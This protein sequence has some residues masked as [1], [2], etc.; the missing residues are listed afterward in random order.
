[1]TGATRDSLGRLARPLSVGSR[2][3]WGALTAGAIL[4]LLGGAAWVVQLGWITAPYWVLATWLL[5]AL[6]AALLCRAALRSDARYSAGGIAAWLEEHGIWRRGAI[7]A[8]LDT[9]APGTSDALLGAA[10]RAQ[11][12]ELNRR[13]AEALAPVRA[14]VRSRLLAGVAALLAGLMLLGSAGPVGGAAA[15]L[16]HPARAWELATAPVRISASAGEV[17]RG[18]SVALHLE[19]PGR[20]RAV[21][22]TRAPGESWRPLAVRLDSAGRGTRVMGPLRSDLYARITSGA[23][24]SDTLMVRVRLP[25]FLGSLTVTARYPRYL[26][27]ADEPVPPGGDTIILPAGTRSAARNSST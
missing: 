18:D 16:W 10:D 3:A 7:T 6:A 20:T 25:V 27:L 26:G 4:L 23:R 12:G 8:L 11:A 5:A 22:W 21:L 13:G 1:M 9:P 24:S 15:A 14:P 17:D 2:A 19:A